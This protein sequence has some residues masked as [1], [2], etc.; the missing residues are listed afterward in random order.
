MRIGA[1]SRYQVVNNLDD[2]TEATLKVETGPVKHALVAGVEFAREGVTRANYQ[3]L[4][5]ELNGIPTGNS[6][7]C[8]LYL[9]C[10][11]LLF[12]NVPYRNPVPTRIAVDTKSGYLIE[13]ANYQDVDVTG[14][15]RFDDYNITSRT[16]ICRHSRR[17]M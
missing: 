9:L 12:L 6:V 4:S 5:S 2:Q 1:Q 11:Y 13:T 3:G 10:T 8:N 17:V 16:E 14:G 15:A 7:T